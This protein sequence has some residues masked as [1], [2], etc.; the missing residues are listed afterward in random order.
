M[1]IAYITGTS[2]GG[3]ASSC[4]TS[5]IDTTGAN[6]IVL[7]IGYQ[8]GS[9]PSISDNKSNTWNALTI[10]STAGAQACRIYYAINPTV[11]SGHTF[12][13]GGTNNYS[14]VSVLAF[15][16][17]DT[18]APFDQ[19]NGANNNSATIQTG[20]VTPT[21][22]NEVC[23]AAVAWNLNRTTEPPT[24]NSSFTGVQGTT[25]SSG[26]HYGGAIAY[27]IQTTAT[28]TNPTW[29]FTNAWTN[30]ARIATFKAA[31]VTSRRVFMIT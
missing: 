4:T 31:A 24:I 8:Q 26:N 5:G 21:Q 28:A 1:A 22:N 16:G 15:S 27:L 6:F 17:V 30:S 11:G 18:S 2:A 13:N 12:S 23:I 10:S 14:T 25:F 7:A 19:Q 29:N 20:S 9:T 3:T